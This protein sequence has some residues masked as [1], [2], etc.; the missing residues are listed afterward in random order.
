MQENSNFHAVLMGFDKFQDRARLPELAF[1]EKDAKDLYSLLIDPQYGE[2]P[3]KNITLVTG[4][5]LLLQLGEGQE[6]PER[7]LSLS[8]GQMPVSEMRTE[9][10]ETILYTQIVKDRTKDDIVLVYYSGHGFVAGKD[11]SAYLATPDVSILDIQSNPRVGLQME[12]LH[13]D[14]FMETEAKFVIFILDCC[15]SGAF[16]A[17]LENKEQT[18]QKYLVESKFY[19]GE[20]RVAFVSSPRGI[21]SREKQGL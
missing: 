2:Y 16:C 6:Q 18:V 17:G 3:L 13:N 15:H 4:N 1:A 10:I 14:I 12:Y 9:D 19:S 20:G 21:T 7:I 5:E 8:N 11:E